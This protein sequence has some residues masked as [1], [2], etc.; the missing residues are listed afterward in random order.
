MNREPYETLSSH[1]V[2]QSPWYTLRQ[3][4]VRLPDGS[5]AEYTVV[6]RAGA[7]W[8]VPLLPD[9]RMVLIRN[10]RYP[11]HEWLWEV[12]AGG[13]KAGIT[14]EETARQE[15]AEE[16]GGPAASLK[17]V[18]TF[19]TAA[20]MSD[21]IA[22]VFLARDVVLGTPHHEPT[23]VMERHVFPVTRV[24]EMIERGEMADGPS[25]LAVLLCLPRLA[26]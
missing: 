13:L 25:A 21:E 23:E 4:Q 8:I 6:E 17:Q 1:V 16:I 12:P 14:P 5:N 26:D 2:W 7:V 10:Y 3:H 20:G 24:T 22:H 9:G 11:V 18:A 15:L 19:Y